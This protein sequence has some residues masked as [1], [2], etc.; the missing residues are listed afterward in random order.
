MAL[1]VVDP[2]QAVDVPEHKD[3]IL[4]T[5]QG[6]NGV[7]E[8]IPV[9][10]AGELV[11]PAVG[12][13]SPP[14]VPDPEHNGKEPGQGGQQQAGG[15]EGIRGGVHHFRI[16]QGP[17]PLG[18][19]AGHNAADSGNPEMEIRLFGQQLGHIRNQGQLFLVKGVVQQL[20]VFFGYVLELILHGFQPFPDPFIGGA[21]RVIGAFL[22][23]V[24]PFRSHVFRQLDDHF[25]DPQVRILFPE[26][27][28]NHVIG[29]GFPEDQFVPGNVHV[30]IFLQVQGHGEVEH[31]SPPGHQGIPDQKVQAGFD[32]VMGGR[33]EPVLPED[34][35]GTV[36][37]GGLL[38]FQQF[39]AFFLFILP[40]PVHV[41][42]LLGSLVHVDHLIG[43]RIADHHQFVHGVEFFP[44]K[45]DPVS[46]EH[47]FPVLLIPG[48]L[49]PFR[50]KGQ[51]VVQV[52]HFRSP[53]QG[54]LEVQGAAVAVHFR[55]AVDGLGQLLD[56]AV[57]LVLQGGL[58]K[59]QEAAAADV[60]QGNGG[61]ME[62]L[63]GF[64]H[65]GQQFPARL[66]PV[67]PAELVEFRDV[68]QEG[69]IVILLVPPGIRILEAGF[70]HAPVAEEAGFRIFQI[71]VPDQF[72]LGGIVLQIVEIAQK[73]HNLIPFVQR[74]FGGYN[75]MGDAPDNAGPQ[76]LGNGPALMHHLF[77]I[78]LKGAGHGVPAHFLVGF[79]QDVLFFQT[80]EFQEG[81][82]GAPE[83]ALAVLPE[84]F[85]GGGAH[86]LPQ[87]GLVVV[88]RLGYLFQ[89]D[90]QG[91]VEQRQFFPAGGQILP[92]P[93]IVLDG[94]QD[95]PG[96]IFVQ[97]HGLENHPPVVSVRP[98]DPELVFGI[99]PALFPALGVEIVRICELEKFFPVVRMD[100]FLGV[101]GQEAGNVRINGVIV[102]GRHGALEHLDLVFPDIQVHQAVVHEHQVPEQFVQ[103]VVEPGVF[104]KGDVLDFQPAQTELGIA[105]DFPGLDPD[106]LAVVHIYQGMGG[107]AVR[108][109]VQEHP[110]L[111]PEGIGGIQQ[112][113]IGFFQ[114]MGAH[115]G[116]N[117]LVGLVD[118]QQGG[119]F[120]GI[121]EQ[122]QGG[123]GH[124]VHETGLFIALVFQAVFRLDVHFQQMGQELFVGQG[125]AVV[126]SLDL[127]TADLFQEGQLF[128]RFHA[129]C[130]GMDSQGLGHEHDGGD[131]F[132]PLVVQVLQEG[133]IDLQLI[134]MVVVEHVQGGIGT[135]EIVQPDFVAAGVE[136]LEGL[137]NVG[138]MLDQG[139]FRHFN[140]QEVPL[141]PVFPYHFFHQMEGVG[142]QEIHPGEV[143]GNGDHGLV[144]PP[145]FPEQ[146]AGLAQYI[147]IQLVDQPGFFQ[148]GHKDPRRDHPP[149]RID[150]SGQGLQAAQF[151]CK[152]PDNGLVVHLDLTGLE[153]PGEVFQHKDPGLLLGGQFRGIDSPGLD[154]VFLDGVTGE[155]GHVKSMAQ[156]G[157]GGT[158]F[159]GIDPR[160]QLDG[161]VLGA[162]VHLPGGFLEFLPEAFCRSQEYETVSGKPGHQLAREQGLKDA[163]QGPEQ[164][165]PGLD[166]PGGIVQLEVG[167][168]QI[169]RVVGFQLSLGPFF[170][171]QV[172]GSLVEGPDPHEPGDRVLF[173]DQHLLGA[174]YQVHDPYGANL[175]QIPFGQGPFHPPEMAFPGPDPEGQVNLVISLFLLGGG[176]L[177]PQDFQGLV[178][179]LIHHALEGASG[180]DLEFLFSGAGIQGQE[181]RVHKKNL[182]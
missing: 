167:Q 159:W 160:L 71:Q 10:Q 33:V 176:G 75:G 82:A 41:V 124:H 129:F 174:A 76:V 77:L 9:P 30:H 161:G 11:R 40:G 22:K 106:V 182:F 94:Q 98:A 3:Q 32:A 127:F 146:F 131:D 27:D 125:T 121:P 169:D 117:L 102:Q 81:A 74:G 63:E 99:H 37:T 96:G 157:Q 69:G 39:V 56:L 115:T 136:F 114:G 148:D 79:P 47:R 92:F 122:A 156:I 180:K 65:F 113:L 179:F 135:A 100:E 42:G 144:V 28:G 61:K 26:A 145:L 181:A 83:P 149:F 93:H 158:F 78:V 177:L 48:F 137:E 91:H 110:E 17:F 105:H 64:H 72:R 51:Q 107:G 104:V 138:G 153:G 4:S 151:A 154:G 130:Q 8:G 54:I 170:P 67:G 101:A 57:Q 163:R 178:V 31:P 147:L 80:V 66:R 49:Q 5:G 50:E 38:S 143:H 44:V 175:G 12:L 97:E 109:L 88:F 139:A 46:D 166:P 35:Q 112:V 140:A 2:L 25:L 171:G 45:D 73:S 134:E 34:G 60:S 172:Q 142:D 118:V 18:E 119:V 58:G 6:G 68:Q 162:L 165:V 90:S 21:H 108:H 132:L 155:F 152:A 85:Q 43:F 1:G 55:N 164:I 62:M 173:P 52:V 84:E 20:Y 19:M 14:V 36:G 141:E 168:V 120:P 89:R 116:Q 126:E 95:V 24:E 86:R 15:P 16:P 133:L 23:N 128:F 123:F 70:Q 103:F 59:A 29:G 111:V 13:E 150:P 87:Q 7:V 53:G